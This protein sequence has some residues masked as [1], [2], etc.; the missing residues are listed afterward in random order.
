MC[1]SISHHVSA[2]GDTPSPEWVARQVESNLAGYWLSLGRLANGRLYVSNELSWE[3]TGGPYFNRVVDPQ[4]SE[5]T[6]DQR[7]EEIKRTFDHRAAA[8]TWLLGPSTTPPDL[9]QHLSEKGC[10]FQE[11]W[12]GMTHSL[13]VVGD[14]PEMPDSVA[15]TE[16]RD[17]STSREWLTVVSR[18][19]GLPRSVRRLLRRSVTAQTS[20]SEHELWKHY[21][22]YVNGRPAAASTLFVRDGVAGIYL[23]STVPEMRGMGLGSYATWLALREA[24][25][26]GCSLAVL[27]STYQARSLYERL[28]FRY[29]CDIGVYRYEAPAPTW[30]RVARSGLRKLRRSVRK[31]M[32][33]TDQGPDL[34]PALAAEYQHS[35]ASF[36]Q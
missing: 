33:E 23:V 20:A 17:Q 35:S 24:K 29:C 4:L 21:L 6:V 26:M 18:S 36:H 28:G 16:V 5:Q 25:E 7:I 15:V 11:S 3:Y 27:Q 12:A 31:A 1:T 32:R 34:D 13:S 8:V 10:T 14:P 19:F 22:L 2:T 9:G 30:K